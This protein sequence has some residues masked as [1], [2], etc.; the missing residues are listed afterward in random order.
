[1]TPGDRLLV[2]IDLR[3]DRAVLEAAYDDPCGVTAAFNRNILARVNRELGGNLDVAAFQH[4]AIYNHDQGRVEM[5]LESTRVQRVRLAAAD[6]DVSFAAQE[7]IHTEN[8]YK[9]SSD[10][11]DTL[12]AAAG[13]R[14]HRHWLDSQRRFSL[15]LL[16]SA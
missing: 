5:Y 2:G 8:S 16:A 12:A 13:L 1:M 4:R 9:Y 14:R 11:I 15:N 6:F 10:E 3:K 7:A